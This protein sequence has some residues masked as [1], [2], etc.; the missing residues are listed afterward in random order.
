MK[1]KEKRRLQQQAGCVCMSYV[2][3]LIS[4]NRWSDAGAFFLAPGPEKGLPRG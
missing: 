1:K 3:F 2:Y 4:V